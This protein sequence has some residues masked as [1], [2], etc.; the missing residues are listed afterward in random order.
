[1]IF[2]PVIKIAS[3]A[4]ASPATAQQKGLSYTLAEPQLNEALLF[5]LNNSCNMR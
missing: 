3:I 1:M 5:S 4:V 2:E